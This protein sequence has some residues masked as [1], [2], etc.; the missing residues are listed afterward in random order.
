MYLPLQRAVTIN[1]LFQP[2]S[3][4]PSRVSGSC[5]GGAESGIWSVPD[6]FGSANP[7]PFRIQPAIDLELSFSISEQLSYRPAS[8]LAAFG[9]C[10]KGLGAKS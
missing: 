6:F 7:D 8:A 9:N 2:S 3:S 1:R 10:P 4:V 5:R